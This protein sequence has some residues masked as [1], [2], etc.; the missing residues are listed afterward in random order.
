MATAGSADGDPVTDSLLVSKIEAS[1]FTNIYALFAS[2]L[3]PFADVA[4]PK[5]AKKP[6]KSRATAA[7]DET[8]IRAVAKR[9]L[10]FL[11]RSLT[12]IP[13]R[14]STDPK[15]DADAAGE[16]LKAY[17]LC[18]SCLEAVACQLS[19]KPWFVYAQRGRMMRCLEGCGRYGDAEEEGF[20]LLRKIGGLDGVVGMLNRRCVPGLGSG[21]V[22]SELAMLVVD[23]VVTIVKC[24]CLR[25]SREEESYKRVLQ[26][27]GESGMWFRVLD[28][29]ASEKLH[30]V[31]VTYLNKCTIYLLESLSD[32][33][34]DLVYMFCSVTLV[35][36][37]RS[38]IKEQTSKFA[39]RICSCI[40][41]QMEKGSSLIVDILHC[42]LQ[43]IALDLKAGRVNTASN[44]LEIISCFSIRCRNVC[45][46]L[47]TSIAACLSDMADT[48]FQGCTQLAS[49]LRI[50]SAGLPFNRDFLESMKDQPKLITLLEDD[51]NLKQLQAVLCSYRS[52]LCNTGLQKCSLSACVNHSNVPKSIYCDALNYLCHPFAELVNSNKKH[53]LAEEEGAVP[54]AN[55]CVIQDAFLML[56]EAFISYQSHTTESERAESEDISKSVLNVAVAALILSFKTKTSI[57]ES[58]N[59][60]ERIMSDGSLGLQGLKFLFVSFYNTGVTLYRS[61][62]L[63][64]ASESLKLCC[65]ASWAIV[66]LLCHMV[67]EKSH[68]C[69]NGISEGDVMNFITDACVKSAFFIDVAHQSS[70]PDVKKELIYCLENWSV[71]GALF[72]NVS[73]PTALV[74]QWVKI[75]CKLNKEKDASEKFPTLSCLLS[76][77]SVPEKTLALLLEQE[78]LEYEEISARFPSFCQEMQMKIIDI[79]LNDIYASKATS[80]QRSKILMKKGKLLRMCGM[81][82]FEESIKCISDAV[83]AMHRPHDKACNWSIQDQHQLAFAYCLRSFSIQEAD[84]S[85]EKVLQDVEAALNIWLSLPE[86]CGTD[87]SSLKVSETTI[88]L[89]YHVLDFLSLQ[90][91]TRFHSNLY[92]LLIKFYKWRNIPAESYLPLLWK[93]R[94]LSHAL[95]ASPVNHDFMAHLSE[96]VGEECKSMEY[97]ISCLKGSRNLRLGFEQK[98]SYVFAS[99]KGSYCHGSSIRQQCPVDEVKEAARNLT[100]KVPLTS[101]SVFLAGHLYY[102]LSE[103]LVHSGNLVEALSYA[104]EAHRL[105]SKLLQD[106][107]TYTINQ[108]SEP[109]HDGMEVE[110]H[111]YSLKNF[112]ITSSEAGK[113]WSLDKLS[114]DLE[115]S[116]LSPWNV[117]QC[118]VESTLQVGVIHEMLGNS[119][120]AEILL[121]W[122]R[123][124]CSSQGLMFLKV[125]FSCVLGKLY[126]KKKLWGLAA[127]ILEEGKHVFSDCKI[128]VTCLKCR[129]IFEIDLDLQLGDLFRSQ[130]NSS[131]GY[132]SSDQLSQ[133]ESLYRTGLYKL[134]LPEWKNSVSCPRQ[135]TEM[136]AKDR[137]YKTKG[138][139]C[140]AHSTYKSNALGISESSAACEKPPV[141]LEPKRSKKIKEVPGNLH[142]HKNSVAQKNVRVTRARTRSSQISNPTKPADKQNGCIPCSNDNGEHARFDALSQ[143]LSF[144]DIN[145]SMLHSGCAMCLRENVQCWQCLPIKVLESGSV[146]SLISL[147]WEFHR[148][149]LSL[150]LLEG[151]GK[152]LL[153]NG[154]THGAHEVYCESIAVLMSRNHFQYIFPATKLDEWFDL[155]NEQ[156]YGDAFA[157]ERAVVLYHVCLHSVTIFHTKNARDNCCDVFQ[158]GYPR[159]LSWLRLAF[160]LCREVPSLFEK[161]SRLLASLHVLAASTELFSLSTSSMKALSDSH[162]AVYFHQ[163]SIG[164]HLNY[165]LLSSWVGKSVS[166]NP[167]DN[168]V[169]SSTGDVEKWD[170]LR[171]APESVQCLDEFVLKFY[172]GLPSATVVCFSLLDGTLT[173]VLRELLG[174]PSTV[175]AWTLLSRFNST[176]EP[177]VI[178][179]PVESVLDDD[180]T[181]NSVIRILFG[182][183]DKD[184]HCPWG[185]TVIDNVVPLFRGLLKENYLSSSR[186]PLEDTMNNRTLWWGRRKKLDQS[187]DT[188]LRDLESTWFGVWKYIFLGGWSHGKH[189]DSITKKLTR[190]LKR[191]CKVELNA[192]LLKIYLGGARYAS[193]RGESFL[194]LSLKNGCFIGRSRSCPKE[195]EELSASMS[196]T[197]ECLS[198]AAFQLILEAANELENQ[199]SVHKE[200]IILVLDLDV[201]MLPLE[202]MPILRSDEVYRMPS[203]GSIAVTLDRRRIRQDQI[204][205]FAPFP[206][207][208][209]QDAFYLLNP[210][211]DLTSTQQEFEKW[212]RDQNLEGKAGEAPSVEELFSALK[213]HDLFIYFGHGSGSQYLPGHEI[214][215]LESCPATLLMGCSSGTLQLNGP[216]LPRGMP[217]SYLMAGSPAIIANL[218]DVTDKDIDR[219]GKAVLDAWLSERSASHSDS[220]ARPKIGSFISKARDACQLPYLIGAAP[221]CYGVPTGICRK[222][223][224]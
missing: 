111:E 204:N 195:M 196:D 139:E 145:D 219:F 155:T 179:Q 87:G 71:V 52:L 78:L 120:D 94:R 199:P 180:D 88:P 194:H 83:D 2:H 143:E 72:T 153:A 102:D 27:V 182:D 93:S 173:K 80:H 212:F 53:I 163:A 167:V 162:W 98:L 124:I 192:T 125:A 132:T 47:Q 121:K 28:A 133:A 36:Y 150:K 213:E 19:C 7:S 55:L 11:N 206:S 117:L 107:F 169:A 40:L 222:K 48:F 136:K 8:T 129:S 122:G 35:E 114:F 217:L 144:L 91:H 100:S 5:P 181:S 95:C 22:D 112:S 168:K 216:Y 82:T 190:D 3:R 69:S 149:K 23:I 130:F 57:E 75:G 30:R 123:S 60:A 18:L 13:K 221:V 115:N 20:W 4:N 203:V 191:K 183:D 108:Q 21:G 67:E 24:V 138:L 110:K 89:I 118:Y 62:Q 210:S 25:E 159:I 79:L 66:S 77:S 103:R 187:L 113:I 9:F 152:C 208:D 50:F 90:V 58:M 146:D 126:R 81:G 15:P 92:K 85:S 166:E 54:A 165:Q 171:P 186:F 141:I 70:N 44:F 131:L 105:R 175:N 197:V 86:Y 161:V 147:K 148:R 109:D 119:I 45:P 101:S 178:L 31:L 164:T 34:E 174:Y 218:W 59:I 128:Q 61:K 64:M 63:T 74:K 177:V 42:V 215:K 201:Q 207:I 193:E 220:E 158:I 73:A 209:P 84:P 49:T 37:G 205:T 12:L 10:P 6:S 140:N 96:H 202:N 33:S 29:N 170:M 200:P 157:I 39:R 32:F 189:L 38:S 223:D 198:T 106:K 224:T 154:Q 41:S 65:R 172:Q 97:W 46:F 1:E 16:L 26:L 43:S 156:T 214:Q 104:K 160:V 135:S 14:L 184:W 134:K 185:S 151:A 99:N 142:L 51:G 76:S 56:C 68:R 137:N 211:G 176:N 127:S 116:S 17:E 188:L